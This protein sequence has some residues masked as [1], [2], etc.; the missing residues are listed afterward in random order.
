MTRLALRLTAA[1]VAAVFLW[2]IATLPPGPAAALGPVADAIR[3]RTIAGALHVHS[4]RSDG[5]GDR[6]AIASAAAT[7]GLRFVVITDHGDATRQPDPPAYLHGVLCFDAVEVSTNGGHVIALD[8]GASPYP[9]GGEAGAVIEDVIRLGGMPIVAH[10][11]SPKSELAWTDTDS[12]VAGIEWLNLDSAWRSASKLRLSRLAFDALIRPG[13]AVARLLDRPVQSLAR[14]DALATRR[15]VVG[16]AGH[17]A[18]GGVGRSEEGSLWTLPGASSYQASFAA[19]GTRVIVDEPLNGT[20][21]SDASAILG[22]LRGGRVF[23]AIDGLASPAF[24][25]FHATLDG[26]ELRM[27]EERA[28]D[29]GA[30]L[31]LGSTVPPGG[32]AVLL[33]DGVEVS[34][35]AT[36]ELQFRP[37]EAG[38]YRVE[39]RLAGSRVPWIVTNPIYLRGPAPPADGLV[40][41]GSR[42]VP[43]LEPSEP[44]VV[45]KDPGS[46][47]TL[48]SSDGS[49]ALSFRLRGGDRV[50][51]YAAIAVSLPTDVREFDSVA[52]DA[53]SSAPLRVSVQLRFESSGGAR[54]RH[55]VYLSPETR[56]IT[57]PVSRLVAADRPGAVPPTRT[58]TSLLFVVDLT[59]ARP[60]AEGQFEIS[61][62]RLLGR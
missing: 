62:L 28:F 3:G 15:R 27:G 1:L 56:T 51:Q 37:R 14:W 48:A 45:E 35:S 11:D 8:M 39:L 59:N 31:S 12:P 55:S 57:V 34:S 24:V 22:A 50:S 32:T 42:A 9:L 29:P 53:R 40:P 30:V 58:A 19:F 47:A 54:W 44:G 33:R 38:A 4:V 20:A 10:P 43:V 5:A 23:T 61:R 49:R 21:A 17:D 16:V 7:A 26:T 25:D 46:S 6:E 60:G 2:I 13:P 52:F 18:H 41:G 36:G